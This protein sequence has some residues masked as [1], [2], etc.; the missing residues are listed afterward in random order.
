MALIFERQVHPSIKVI[1]GI[2]MLIYFGSQ[3]ALANEDIPF[4]HKQLK[5]LKDDVKDW[6]KRCTADNYRERN[7]T[8]CNEEK[9]YNQARIRK[10][11]SQCFYDGNF[12]LY[13]NFYL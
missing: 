6:K 4:C 1:V 12:D 2:V 10:H 13:I 9:K 8:Q 11:T 5:E 7:I 3:L